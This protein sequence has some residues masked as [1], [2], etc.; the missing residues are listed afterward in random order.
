MI[1]IIYS[2]NLYRGTKPKSNFLRTCFMDSHCHLNI[3]INLE[4][5]FSI[6]CQFL[7]FFWKQAIFNQIKSTEHHNWFTLSRPKGKETLKKTSEETKTDIK[8]VHVM[9]QWIVKNKL[10]IIYSIE[11]KSNR[12]YLLLHFSLWNLKKEI[13]SIFFRKIT[14][15]FNI[16]MEYQTNMFCSLI[17]LPYVKKQYLQYGWW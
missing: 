13:C 16:W 9:I 4:S 8:Q 2:F 12:I 6:V 7:I 14:E 15:I 11:H 10:K 3:K 5:N 17:L 1:I